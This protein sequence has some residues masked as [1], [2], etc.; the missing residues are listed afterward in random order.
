M[1][2]K[3]TNYTYYPLAITIEKATE[4]PFEEIWAELLPASY[5]MFGFFF[6]KYGTNPDS[7]VTALKKELECTLSKASDV[8]T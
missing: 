4:R 5:E 7:A 1:E 6:Q 2:A 8:S 3:K